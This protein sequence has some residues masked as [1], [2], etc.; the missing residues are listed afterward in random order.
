M[1]LPIYKVVRF[2]VVVYW[3]MTPCSLVKYMWINVTKPE[4]GYQI[5]KEWASVAKEA[6]VLRRP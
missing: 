1:R 4:D 2:Q 6:K 3:V 5:R